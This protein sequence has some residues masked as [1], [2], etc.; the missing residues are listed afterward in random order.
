MFKTC[1]LRCHQLD[2][3]DQYK[4]VLTAI[5]RMTFDA[6]KY[7]RILQHYKKSL[8]RLIFKFV[9]VRVSRNS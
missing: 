2:R 8:L 1:E 7:G 3:R 5:E 6:A 4:G 9:S